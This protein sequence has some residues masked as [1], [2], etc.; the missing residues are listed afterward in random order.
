[1][2]RRARG[3]PSGP[4]PDRAP[5]RPPRASYAAVDASAG[6][7][8]E[9]EE[10]DARRSTWRERASEY[11][12][13]GGGGGRRR[14]GGGGGGRRGPHERG[15]LRDGRVGLAGQ[16]SRA[17]EGP[18][19]MFPSY[20]GRRGAFESRPGRMDDGD[21]DGAAALPGALRSM[22]GDSASERNYR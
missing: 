14:G 20:G 18:E 17:T 21:D 5:S 7:R 3:E 15:V 19:D 9:E 6:R 8:G 1:V 12:L 16:P 2:S 22:S 13:A 10:V 11:I 4:G